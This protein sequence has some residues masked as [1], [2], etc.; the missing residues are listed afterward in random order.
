MAQT[1]QQEE[2]KLPPL[3]NGLVAWFAGPGLSQLNGPWVLHLALLPPMTGHQ[4]T[5][6]LVELHQILA[7][8]GRHGSSSI[9]GSITVGVM[10]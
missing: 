6:L 10:S 9:D 2:K 7:D 1:K 5:L 4:S 3:E 8:L